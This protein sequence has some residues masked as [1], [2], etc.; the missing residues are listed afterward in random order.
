MN[1]IINVYKPSGMTSHDVVSRLRKLLNIKK[2]GHTGTLD[3][4]AVGVLPMCIGRATKTADMLTAADKQYIAEV[5]LGC[6]TDT[7]DKS[8]TV[9][10]S[11]QVNV[12]E[13]DIQRI[14]KN[15]EG[16]IT[17]VPPM[18]SAIKVNGQKLC[19]LAREGKEVERKP[20][21]ITIYKIEPLEF[22][23]INNRFT[24]RVDCSK[25]TYIRTLCTDIGRRLGCYAHMSTLER[26]RSGRFDKQSSYTLEKIEK[27]INDNDLSFLTPI[28]KVFS[29]FD[30]LIISER[31][32]KLMQNG[33]QISVYGI[34]DGKTYRVYDETG[35]F[36]TISTAQDGRL[37]I[38]HTFYQE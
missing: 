34:N 8:G 33:M 7:Q 32:S 31:K 10:N 20:R 27:M 4:D 21:N 12:S 24:I 19:D 3:P 15:F 17:Q 5:T 38:L 18:Y 16:N 2:I 9:I 37:K 13:A 29:E 26:T 25:G 14:L 35:K 6:E 1:G 22:D 11:A 30:E 28:D 36:L 23:L